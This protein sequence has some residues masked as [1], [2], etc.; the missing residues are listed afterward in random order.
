[1]RAYVYTL[2]HIL[3]H[4]GLSQ[5]T[6]DGSLKALVFIHSKCDSLYLLTSNSQFILLPPSSP[7]AITSLFSMFVSLFLFCRY[8][9]L[10]HILDNTYK[11]CYMV[12]DLLFLTYQM[13]IWILG[14]LSAT[15]IPFQYINTSDEIRGDI[16]WCVF[17][18]TSWNLWTFR[19]LP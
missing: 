7:L 12:F 19:R 1:M 15:L 8:V 13:K 2:F 18:V 4:H 5:E 11:W 3:S 17:D 10:C 14:N 9:H 6:G 16:N